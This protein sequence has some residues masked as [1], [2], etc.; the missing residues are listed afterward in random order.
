VTGFEDPQPAGT[1]YL[2]I[3]GLFTLAAFAVIAVF[4]WLEQRREREYLMTI[5]A[6]L[7]HGQA[8]PPELVRGPAPTRTT[9]I[10]R[11]L[12]AIAV[13]AALVV[14]FAVNPGIAGT[15]ALG[16]LPIAVGLA[17]IAGAFLDDNL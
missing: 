13:G 4:A 1:E 10:R 7:E 11:G 6:F 12:L 9:R 14:I 15:W 3:V 16:L 17:R 5:R 2:I 8:P